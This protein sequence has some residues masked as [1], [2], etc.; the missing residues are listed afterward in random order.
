MFVLGVKGRNWRIAA[1]G[2]ILASF[3]GL[4]LKELIHDLS[5]GVTLHFP[6]LVQNEIFSI[7]EKGEVY[8]LEQ[9]WGFS[10]QEQK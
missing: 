3:L 6:F 10:M 8:D 1:F 9:V 5:Q 7:H 4:G 2:S